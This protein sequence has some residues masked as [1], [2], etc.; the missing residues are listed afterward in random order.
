MWS[1]LLKYLISGDHA[2]TSVIKSLLEENL[3]EEFEREIITQFFF[4]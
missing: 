3:L 2:R 1:A 4:G